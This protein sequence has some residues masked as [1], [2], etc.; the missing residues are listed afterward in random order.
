MP[1]ITNLTKVLLLSVATV[2]LTSIL[3]SAGGNKGEEGEDIILYKNNLVIRES[4]GKGKGKGKG[5]GRGN[6]VLAEGKSHEEHHHEEF[7]GDYFGGHHEGMGHDFGH[8]DSF[9]HKM[10]KDII[11]GNDDNVS[12]ANVRNSP[13]QSRRGRTS[14]GDGNVSWM[15]YLFRR[16]PAE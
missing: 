6:L 1:H 15:Q 11:M 13:R 12:P 9:E 16:A 8:G 4:G 10:I 2:A 5:G 3:V 14:S 7:G